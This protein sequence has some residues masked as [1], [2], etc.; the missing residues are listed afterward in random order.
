MFSYPSSLDGGAPGDE[1]KPDPA[2]STRP[3][4]AQGRSA[5]APMELESKWL[6]IDA[7]CKLLGVDQSTLRRWSDNGKIPV[8]RTPGGHRRYSE[9]DLRALVRGEPRR[10]RVSRQVLTTRSMSA[11]EHDYLGQARSRSWYRAYDPATLEQLRPLGRRMV[12]LTIRYISG[13]GE[14]DGILTES[15]ELGFQYGLFSARV[16]LSTAEALEAF[17][18]FRTPVIRAVTDYIEDENV[19]T[20]RAARITSELNAF[21]D[22]VLIATIRAHQE[23]AGGD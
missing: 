11:Y 4:P 9:D 6:S 15:R 7:A 1:R 12:D 23:H 8:F 2:P 14:R 19:P 3:R 22:Q 10:K 21:L 17:L 13:R 16:G 20:Q 18:F 5:P